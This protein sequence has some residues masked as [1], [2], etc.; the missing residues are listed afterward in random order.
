M[1]FLVVLIWGRQNGV[2][3]LGK[4][5]RLNNAIKFIKELDKTLDFNKE[6]LDSSQTFRSSES[7]N[8]NITID[9]TIKEARKLDI[10]V[11]KDRKAYFE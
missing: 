10:I 2:S 5:I 11:A 4:Q 7:S 9:G 1:L 6:I 8:K 3:L